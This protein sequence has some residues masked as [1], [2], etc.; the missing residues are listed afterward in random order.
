V[1]LTAPEV[2]WLKQR[3]RK[4]NLKTATLAAAFLRNAMQSAGAPRFDEAQKAK[5]P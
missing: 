5:R 3:S 4:V 2:A 1:S